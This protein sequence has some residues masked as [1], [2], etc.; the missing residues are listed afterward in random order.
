MANPAA[1]DKILT[2]IFP[3]DSSAGILESHIEI[4]LFDSEIDSDLRKIIHEEGRRFGSAVFGERCHTRLSDECGDCGRIME[5]IDG[6]G[7]RCPRGDC[8]SNRPDE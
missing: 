1:T 5:P 4:N 7:F 6:A 3:G 8:P 2:V